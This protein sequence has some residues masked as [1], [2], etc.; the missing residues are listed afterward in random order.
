MEEGKL[1][2]RLVKHNRI[3]R[4]LVVPCQESAWE[5]ALREGCHALDVSVPVLLPRH[6]RD[7]A[8]FKQMRFVPGDFMDAVAFDRMEAEY[9]DLAHPRGADR[10]PRNE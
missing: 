1:W 6:L 7:W 3:A 9:F 10:D 2:I 4:D 5:D 8:E